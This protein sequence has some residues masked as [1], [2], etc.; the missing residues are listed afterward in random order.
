MPDGLRLDGNDKL[1]E[2][3][4]EPSRKETSGKWGRGGME[5]ERGS[6]RNARRRGFKRAGNSVRKR[7]GEKQAWAAMGEKRFAG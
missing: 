5:G 3:G 4:L 6:R 2:N 7:C 1:G